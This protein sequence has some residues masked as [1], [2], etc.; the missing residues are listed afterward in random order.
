MKG[1][2]SSSGVTFQLY[3][4]LLHI[5]SVTT[6]SKHLQSWKHP[7]LLPCAFSHAV[8][9]GWNS[10]SCSS[11]RAT[12]TSPLEPLL[13]FVHHWPCSDTSA[14][15]A[16]ILRVLPICSYSA[17]P[18]SGRIL[19]HCLFAC[20]SSPLDYQLLNSRHQV[21]GYLIPKSNTVPDT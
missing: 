7:L 19:F 17:L 21:F 1:Q 9:H 18:A 15:S 13:G 14:P 20:L 8:S 4:L 10:R 5:I 16:W 11:H 2:R 3:S 12:C 6:I